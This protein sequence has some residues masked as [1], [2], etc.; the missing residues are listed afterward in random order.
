MINET[1]ALQFRKLI[2]LAC[3]PFF[4]GCHSDEVKNAGQAL[5]TVNGQDITIHQVNAELPAISASGNPVQMQQRALQQVIDRELLATQ[6]VKTK[7][8]RDPAVLMAI[9]RSKA[10]ILAQAYV[11]GRVRNAGQPAKAEIDAYT[12]NHP[13]LFSNRKLFSLRYLSMPSAALTDEV[14]ALADQVK[15]LDELAVLLR[16]RKIAYDENQSYRSTAELPPQLL[17][18]L[19][20]LGNGTI[21]ILRD[22]GLAL[23]ASLTFVKDAPV[24]GEAAAQQAEQFLR[25]QKS[26]DL[27]K[28]EV[29]RLRQEAKIIYAKGSEPIAAA[30]TV[31]Q[32]AAAATGAVS[33]AKSATESGISGLR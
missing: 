16:S 5:A 21:F 10:Q 33:G 13:V 20:R 23:L 18:N 8:D 7:L 17:S 15:T 4:I 32:P 11:Q 1:S 26:I 12:Q 2:V 28:E 14:G 9:E 3:L 24:T 22:G 25:N 29:T 30:Q 31:A 6:A 27:A 19:G